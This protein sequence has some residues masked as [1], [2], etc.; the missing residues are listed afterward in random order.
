MK[1]KSAA[2][3]LDFLAFAQMGEDYE[4]IFHFD[5]SLLANLS[6]MNVFTSGLNDLLQPFTF[7]KCSPLFPSRSSLLFVKHFRA[8]GFGKQ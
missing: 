7:N 1:K 2:G 4:E 3:A 8:S 5:G 6:G